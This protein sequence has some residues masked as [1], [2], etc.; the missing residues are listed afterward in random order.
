MSEK[1]YKW[2]KRAGAATAAVALSVAAVHVHNANQAKRE[3]HSPAI[4]GPLLAD[5]IGSCAL[6][7]NDTQKAPSGDSMLHGRDVVEY[8]IDTKLKPNVQPYYGAFVNSNSVLWDDH[9]II[10]RAHNVNYPKAMSYLPTSGMERAS[11]AY[12]TKD[13]KQVNRIDPHTNGTHIDGVISPHVKYG[14]GSFVDIWDNE[15]TTYRNENSSPTT[16]LNAI[17][18]GRMVLNDIA[19]TPTWQLDKTVEHPL[20]DVKR[21]I[22]PEL[23]NPT[24]QDVAL[25]PIQHIDRSS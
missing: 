22:V 6:T 13:G 3:I 10:T 21:Q 2:A 9:T 12:P 18:C 17:Y 23:S 7:I 19:G 16:S 5:R 4:A 15:S 20:Q 14:V 8:K 1:A 24:D 11:V 25:L